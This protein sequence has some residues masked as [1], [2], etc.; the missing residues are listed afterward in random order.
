MFKQLS[1]SEV[2]EYQQ[3]ARDNFVPGEE[4]NP[5][6]HPVIQKQCLELEWEYLEGNLGSGEIDVEGIFSRQQEIERQL[7]EIDLILSTL[8]Q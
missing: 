7:N 5:V 1:E 8:G 3:W 4:V 2:A 6:F